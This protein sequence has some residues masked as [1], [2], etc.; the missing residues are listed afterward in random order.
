MC[1]EF[2]LEER[3]WR[4]ALTLCGRRGG[5]LVTIQEARIQSFLMRSLVS[6]RWPRNGVWI[7]ATDKDE[8]MKWKWIT[9]VCVWV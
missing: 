6:Y 3:T 8:E 5:T 7:G 1:Y 2:H 9:G 4:T